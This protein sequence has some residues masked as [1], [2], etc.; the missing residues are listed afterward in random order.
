MV[1]IL[2]VSLL[3]GGFLVNVQD[4][5]IWLRWGRFL[6]VFYYAFEPLISNEV[7][8]LTIVYDVRLCSRC[9]QIYRVYGGACA[10]SAAPLSVWPC[11]V[12]RVHLAKIASWKGF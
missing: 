2:L 7:Q 6:S 10:R 9:S 4:I 5:P 3:F 1:M 12:G 11:C 8:G